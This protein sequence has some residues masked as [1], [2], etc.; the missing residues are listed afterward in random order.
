MKLIWKAM[1][2]KVLWSIVLV[3]FL[4]Y[5]FPDFHTLIINIIILLVMIPVLY[6]WE[7]IKLTKKNS[8]NKKLIYRRFR[9]E[10]NQLF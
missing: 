2:W 5:Q 6:F 10:D 8:N 9:N 4:Y 3:I 1:F 7:K